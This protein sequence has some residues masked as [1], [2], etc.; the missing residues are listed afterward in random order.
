MVS[1]AHKLKNNFDKTVANL[2]IAGFTGQIKGWWDNVLTTQQQTEILETIQ[3]NEL[4]EPILDSNNET[5]E[6]AVSILIYY[7]VKYFLGD[8]TYLQDYQSLCLVESFVI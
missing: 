4:K 1:N 5:I 3:V 7:I 6:D 8:P 2:L